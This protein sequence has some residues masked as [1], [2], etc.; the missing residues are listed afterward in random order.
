VL[1]DDQPAGLEQ[2]ARGLLDQADDVEAVLAREQRDLGVVVDHLGV[3]DVPLGGG[4]VG[5]VA[6]H[7]VEGAVHAGQA[8]LD[9]AQVQLHLGSP[10]LTRLSALRRV[11]ASAPGSRSTAWTTAPGTSLASAK[12][13]VPLPVHRS[14]SSGRSQPSAATASTAHCTTDSVSG[15]GTNTPGP[16]SSST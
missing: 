10:A 12:A 2:P 1:D 16:T 15:R 13:M 11:Q 3:R 7:Q 5:R 6:G 8:V 4:D 14:A 9:A